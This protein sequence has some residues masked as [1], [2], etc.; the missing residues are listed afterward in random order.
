MV[1]CNVCMYVTIEVIMTTDPATMLATNIDF[2][3]KKTYM[4]L[5]YTGTAVIGY[6]KTIRAVASTSLRRQVAEELT[7][8][9]G[10]LVQA[11]E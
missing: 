1:S 5:T 6:Y 10:A 3:F 7:A 9:G 4:A 2:V 8:Q 11:C